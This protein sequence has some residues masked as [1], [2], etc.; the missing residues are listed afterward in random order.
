WLAR[1]PAGA[2]T[3]LW[4]RWPT[5]GIRCPTRPW[6]TSCAGMNRPCAGEE[7]NDHL[8]GLYS[9]A[10][11]RS[12]R[13]GFLHG[14]S[15]DLARTGDVLRSIFHSPGEPEGLHRRNHGSSG[16]M[17]D[18]SGSLQRDIGGDG[19][20]QRLSLHVARSRYQVLP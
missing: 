4:G 6:A 11:G 10:H 2:T 7:P 15:A 9:P 20:S 3:G 14:R 16:G 12:R 13:H 8:E 18:A 19:T 1:T 5:W 17:L